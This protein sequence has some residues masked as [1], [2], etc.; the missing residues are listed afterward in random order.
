[1]Q[2]I[3]SVPWPYQSLSLILPNEEIDFEH[4]AFLLSRY[5]WRNKSGERVNYFPKVI[6]QELGGVSIRSFTHSMAIS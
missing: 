1:M 2:Y 5:R 3:L 6:S 4:C